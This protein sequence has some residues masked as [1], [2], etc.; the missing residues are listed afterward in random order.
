MIYFLE[1]VIPYIDR[2]TKAVYKQ[3]IH[4]ICQ[5]KTNLLHIIISL[6]EVKIQ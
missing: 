3:L 6:I 5:C 4:P 2:I 1:F